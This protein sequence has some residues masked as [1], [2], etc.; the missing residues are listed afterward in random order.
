[1][2]IPL[3]VEIEPAPLIPPVL[4]NVLLLVNVVT[5]VSCND[6]VPALT[7]NPPEVEIDPTPLM[8]VLFNI[9]PV[10]SHLRSLSLIC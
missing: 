5:S 2:V 8:L 1:M 3:L 4:V 7:V 10:I 6:V 9:E